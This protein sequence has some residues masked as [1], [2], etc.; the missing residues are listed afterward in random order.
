MCLDYDGFDYGKDRLTWGRGGGGGVG[1]Y[2]VKW[3]G[4]VNNRKRSIY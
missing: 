4:K 1:W 3:E 2:L